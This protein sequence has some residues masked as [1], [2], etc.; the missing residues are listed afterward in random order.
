MTFSYCV[1]R[2]A[3]NVAPSASLR[4]SLPATAK[5]KARVKRGTDYVWDCVVRAFAS[6][7]AKCAYFGLRVSKFGH[8][9]TH[10]EKGTKAQSRAWVFGKRNFGVPVA[11]L[12][13]Y[14]EI[15]YIMIYKSVRRASGSRVPGFHHTKNQAIW[16]AK[17]GKR[18]FKMANMTN[19]KAWPVNSTFLVMLF[20]CQKTKRKEGSCNAFI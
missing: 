5:Q 3:Y 20:S 12:D 14:L 9:K 2:Y 1:V 7:G 8:D 16:D 18:R 6:L 4:A 17:C 13:N 11:E 19:L 15:W 10:W